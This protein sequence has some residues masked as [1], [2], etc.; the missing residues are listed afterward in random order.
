MTVSDY[1][2]RPPRTQPP[3]EGASGPRPQEAGQGA[4]GTLQGGMDQAPGEAVRQARGSLLRGIERARILAAEALA[5]SAA[6]LRG[7]TTAADSTARRFAD[8][9]DR[10]ATYL[11]QTDLRGMQRD[12]VDLVRRHPLQALGLAF[13]AGMLVGQRLSRD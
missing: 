2:R 12:A 8:N 3:Q 10:G 11:R 9:L 5:R 13:L 6:S 4:A 1:T 7:P